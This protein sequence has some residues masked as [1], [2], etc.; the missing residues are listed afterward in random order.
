MIKIRNQKG[1]GMIEVLIALL[2]LAI[3]V[4][5]FTALQLK[6]VDATDEAMSKIEA[7]NIARD[8]AERIRVNRNSLATYVDELN[9]TT[10]INIT[11][12]GLKK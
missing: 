12:S 11:T 9:K 2:L 3:G 4:M 1:V 5:G 10:Q 6:A 8:V 7:M